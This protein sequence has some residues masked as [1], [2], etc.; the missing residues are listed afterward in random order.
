MNSKGI[1]R[2]FQMTANETQTAT[3]LSVFGH[4][5]NGTWMYC[6]KKKK[7]KLKKTQKQTKQKNKQ[8][9]LIQVDFFH[10]NDAQVLFSHIEES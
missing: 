1:A 10:I 5:W 8:N 6:S 7:L 2:L 9:P 4:G 3:W